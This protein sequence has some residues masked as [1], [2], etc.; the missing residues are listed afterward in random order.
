MVKEYC[1]IHED[2][3]LVKYCPLCRAGHG[4]T[5]AAKGMTKRAKVNRARKAAKA[6][7]A[8]KKRTAK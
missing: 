1:E 4:G 2:T 8:T 5:K 6:R 7:W 3:E